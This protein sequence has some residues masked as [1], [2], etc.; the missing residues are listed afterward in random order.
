MPKVCYDRKNCEGYFVCVTMAPEL[1]EEADDDKVD[2]LGGKEQEDGLFVKEIDEDGLEDAKQ[3][4]VGCPADVIKV[5][6][7]DGELLAGPEELPIE[8]A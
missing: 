6:A 4:A 8:S 3:A 5:V 1:F 7:D 2:L